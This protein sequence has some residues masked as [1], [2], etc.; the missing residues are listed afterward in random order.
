M[1][2]SCDALA[3]EVRGNGRYQI[4]LF[5][6]VSNTNND[7]NLFRIASNF[8]KDVPLLGSTPGQM[9]HTGDMLEAHVWVDTIPFTWNP[10][11]QPSHFPTDIG[12]RQTI[13]LPGT[14]NHV[15]TAAQG[16]A[17]IAPASK[18]GLLLTIT[19]LNEVK[20]QFG[21]FFDETKGQDFWEDNIGITPQID[22]LTPQETFAFDLN[23]ISKAPASDGIEPCWAYE[24]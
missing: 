6:P 7:L 20:T 21:G 3:K 4:H 2:F 24:P 16:Y 10:A 12:T 13:D 23:F 11:S 18:P 1:T 17:P 14:C 8:L 22:A 15:D 9:G 19:S 5:Q